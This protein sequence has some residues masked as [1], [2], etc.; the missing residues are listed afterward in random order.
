MKTFQKQ[1]L[2]ILFAVLGTFYFSG[3]TAQTVSKSETEQQMLKKADENIEKFRKGNAEIQFKDKDGRPIQN[4]KVELVQ[5]SHDFLFGCIIF[6]L[7][8]DKNT[9]QPELFKERFKKLFN[10]AVF[11]F[12]WSAY[13]NQQGKP[14][15]TKMTSTLEWCKLNGITTKG[16]PLVWACHSGAPKWLK[17][18]DADAATD[19]LKAR[20][21][22]TVAG[23]KGQINLWDVVNEPVNVRSWN[24]KLKN[25]DSENDWDVQDSISEIADYVEK[26]L[27]WAHSANPEATLLINEYNSIPKVSVRSRYARL[28]KELQKR[29]AP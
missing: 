12:Y 9:Y 24:N 29:N 8:N 6:D 18:Y 2:A 7:V 25:F 23:F 22:N 26:S 27:R 15:W 17:D 28:L 3:T 14:Q 20:V 11:P 1:S 16:H 4:V 10:L 21:I 19:L 5:K 13:E